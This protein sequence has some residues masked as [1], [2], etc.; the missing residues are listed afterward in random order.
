[1]GKPLV[2]LIEVS[3]SFSI[4][5]VR[6]DTVREHPIGFFRHSPEESLDVLKGVSLQLADGEALG[7][8][9]RNGCGKSTLLKI[10]SGIYPPDRGSVVV[11]VSLTPILE[12]GVGWNPDLD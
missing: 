11:R 4:P 12:L 9:G 7:I 8:M 3:K 5:R 10:L 1:M 2:E 6:R